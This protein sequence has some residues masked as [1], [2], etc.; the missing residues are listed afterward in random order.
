MPIHR[1]NEIVR[2]YANLLLFI[3]LAIRYFNRMFISIVLNCTKKGKHERP[4]QQQ[5]QNENVAIAA[6]NNTAAVFAEFT[7]HKILNAA[8]AATGRRPPKE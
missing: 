6:S 1:F 8:V 7:M 3:I 4:Q 5:Q 2:F